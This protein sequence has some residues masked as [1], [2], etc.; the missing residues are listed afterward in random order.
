MLSAVVLALV[1]IVLLYVPGLAVARLL[2]L[3]GLPMI[4]VAP[5][6]TFAMAGISTP[7]LGKADIPWNLGT[8]AAVLGVFL[9][10]SWLL[11]RFVLTR[12]DR[13]VRADAPGAAHVDFEADVTA[14]PDTTAAAE[15]LAPARPRSLRAAAVVA[16]GVMAG[17]A[18]GLVAVLRGMGGSVETVHQGWDPAWHANFTQWISDTG[19]ASPLRAGLFQNWDSGAPTYYPSATHAVRSLVEQ[20]TG[21]ATY[22]LVNM[23]MLLMAGMLV[24]LG[25]AALTWYVSKRN[26]LATA[27]AAAVS[28]WFTIFPS[29][30]IWR[31]AL[32]FAL[33]LTLLGPVL[34]VLLTAVTER[35]RTLVAAG[36]AIAGI[37][38]MHTSLAFC[39]A[40][41]VLCWLAVRALRP[42]RKLVKEIGLLAGT[43]TV[44]AVSILPQVNGVL[45]SAGHVAGFDWRLGVSTVE[46][47]RQVFG[48]GFGG[49]QLG[50]NRDALPG[51]YVLAALVLVGAVFALRHRRTAWLSA[52]FLFFSALTVHASV[53]HWDLVKLLTTPWY[54]DPWRIAAIAVV[55]GAPLVGI[56]IAGLVDLV[57]APRPAI[58]GAVAAAIAVALVLAT[59]IGYNDRNANRV[60][61]GYGERV[62]DKREIE[63]MRLLGELTGGQG[64]V[65]NAPY[66]GSVWMY[67]VGKQLPVL[68]HYDIGYLSK[69]EEQLT[70]HL[71]RWNTD[72][73]VRAAAERLGVRYL[74][75][76]TGQIYAGMVAPPGYQGIDQVEGV[77]V[78]IDTGTAKVY[79]LPPAR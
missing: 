73:A 24:P 33:G 21:Q 44:A 9:V 8:A 58:T 57:P 51:Q 60:S 30:E 6:V 79:E 46:A 50:T 32:P 5:A 14:D 31:T 35:P 2:C 65:L 76:A 47:T 43:A 72:P 53:P 59:G 41:F 74:Y 40:F 26:A 3:R 48:L 15:P 4:A 28:T 37:A 55:A 49:T 77:K 75:L 70:A 62:L 10:F 56:G 54:N 61:F 78:V 64:R 45:A 66:D 1:Y 18:A 25:V 16:L 27:F 69:D 7:L 39:V 42:S 17:S 22:R 68:M 71:N 20:I 29:D 52:A 38:S 11:G 23:D 12:S 63:A 19:L 36:L 34:V 13:R 67:S